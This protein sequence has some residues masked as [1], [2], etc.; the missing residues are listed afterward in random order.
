MRRRLLDLFA[1]WGYELVFPPIV[2]YIESLATGAGRDLE[3]RMFKLTDQLDG[4]LLGV[5][6]DMTPQVARADAHQL[7]REEPN[8]LCY[9]GQTLR[10]LPEGLQGSRASIQFGAELFG[11]AGTESDAEILSL[12]MTA[13]EI[14]GV[15]DVHLDLGHVAIY[16]NIV[17]L[18]GM[19]ESLEAEVF[20]AMQRKDMT[21]L[22]QLLDGA[23]I[24]PDI[25]SMLLLL[26]RLNGTCEASVTAARTGLAAAG[27]AVSNA[28]DEL[29]RVA[30]WIHSHYPD[31][32]LHVDLAELR[33]YRYHTGLVFAAFVAERGQEIARGGRYDGVGQAFGHARPATG[34]SADLQSLM[35]LADKQPESAVKSIAAPWDDSPALR[36]TI[37]KLRKDG[38]R[39]ISLLPG[40]TGDA[41]AMGCDCQLEEKQ[42]EWILRD[43]TEQ[44]D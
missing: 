23:D 41:R 5:R 19:A 27:E 25:A 17:A 20:S 11:H 43:L 18:A 14:A 40:Q 34:F 36:T 35:S 22:K 37:E 32:P 2:D 7:K 39:V 21:T 12:M 44:S 30:R 26:P 3:H 13:I 24:E 38:F 6:A 28:L 15:R 42:G 4:R 33:G 31:T 10:T 9:L 29:E 16:R 8:R 1:S